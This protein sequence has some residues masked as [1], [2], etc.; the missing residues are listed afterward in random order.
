MKAVRIHAPGGAEAL[1]LEDVPRPQPKPGEAL[2]RMEAAG[3][4]FIDV[5]FRTGAYKA[6]SF[7][8]TIGQEGAGV[9]EAV[10]DG[11]STVRP[12]DR[13]ASVNF[14][15]AYAEYAVAPAERLVPVPPR[16]SPSQAAAAMLQGM[17]AQYLAE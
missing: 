6:V 4:N 13:V 9:V 14:S 2:V 3:V 5:Y 16:V 17:T 10:G 7:P 8:L 12:G 1:V 11:A 15:G